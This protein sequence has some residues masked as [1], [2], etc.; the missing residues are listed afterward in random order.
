MGQLGNTYTGLLR[1]I[2]T[3]YLGPHHLYWAHDSKE[4]YSFSPEHIPFKVFD[5]DNETREIQ[6]LASDLPTPYTKDDVMAYLNTN[7][8]EKTDIETLVI[9]IVGGADYLG[10]GSYNT[11]VDWN[12]IINKPIAFPPVAHTHSYNDLTDKPDLTNPINQ[13]E[14]KQIIRDFTVGG[15]GIDLVYDSELDVLR[16]VIT[17]DVQD[18]INII[19]DINEED[20]ISNDDVGITYFMN[21]LNPALL[22]EPQHNIYINVVSS[23]A[24]Q[25]DYPFEFN[26]G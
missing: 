9:E 15:E 17:G 20:L 5:Q 10:E 12:S 24:K 25:F 3:T 22:I 11:S 19:I 14:V 2:P 13:A 8:I 4:L 6:I 16:F 21:N 26:L 7:G 18:N 1:D 23:V